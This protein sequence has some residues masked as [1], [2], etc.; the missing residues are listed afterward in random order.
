MAT[1][2]AMPILEVRDVGASMAFYA[3][4]GFVSGA[5]WGD[6]PEFAIVQRGQVTLGLTYREVPAMHAWWA[7][8][9]YVDDVVA[10]HAEYVAEGLDPTDIHRP[11]HYE[12]DDFDLIDPD[13]HRIAF[14]Q[15]RSP[16]RVGRDR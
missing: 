13:G 10:L 7:A 15:E 2:R 1:L 12:C 16:H 4:A 8:Y 11:A 3:R 14:G 6:P 9:L 5:P